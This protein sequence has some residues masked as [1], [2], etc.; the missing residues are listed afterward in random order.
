MKVIATNIGTP[1]IIR[2]QQKDEQTGIFKHPVEGPIWL[3]A[4]QVS[5]DTVSD[6]KHHGGIYKACYLFSSDN[7]KY[8]RQL[9]PDLSW[10]WGMF[11]ENI[12][13]EGMSE[14]DLNIGSKYQLG[15]AVVQITIPREPC[16]K[17]GIRFNDQKII[18]QFIDHGH[19]GTYVR[20]LKEGE[21]KKGDIFSIIEEVSNSISIA[22]LYT[23]LYAKEPRQEILN[24]ALS[25]EYLPER[26][27][28]KLYRK[29]KKRP[30]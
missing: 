1:T 6:R 12:T 8:W 24:T 14:A 13:L 3:E 7:Y 11:G 16:Y 29:Q 21:V 17:L 2:W 20:V 9:Y 30:V 5:N 22:D 4:S 27:R 15:N 23:L 10:N 28:K 19:P 18:D 26:T 25:C